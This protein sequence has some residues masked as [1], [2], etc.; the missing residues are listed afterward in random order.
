MNM[1]VNRVPNHLA[2]AIISTIISTCTCCG[3]LG[4]FSGIVAIVFA[5]KVNSAV[6]AGDINGA[7]AASNTA[8]ILCWVTTVFAILGLLYWVW[9]FSTAGVAGFEDALRQGM[10]AAKQNR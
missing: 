2:W 5:A 4:L 7:Q 1:S 3:F 9:V 6:A 10:E 8:K